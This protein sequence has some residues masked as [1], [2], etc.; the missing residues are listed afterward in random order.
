MFMHLRAPVGLKREEAP[1][2][3]HCERS[4]AISLRTEIASSLPLL[5]M[6]EADRQVL[7]RRKDTS[8]DTRRQACPLRLSSEQALTNSGQAPAGIQGRGLGMNCGHQ[9]KALTCLYG[10]LSGTFSSL[11]SKRR[12]ISM[13]PRYP[14]AFE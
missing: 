12:F 3:C 4:E 14:V 11:K 2:L 7:F 6:T 1:R 8:C 13:S 5:A 9:Q 10:G